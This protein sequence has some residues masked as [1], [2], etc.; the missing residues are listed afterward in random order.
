M[1]SCTRVTL[2]ARGARTEALPDDLGKAQEIF[3]RSGA[4][5]R[6]KDLLEHRGVLEDWYAYERKSQ[7]QEL[8]DWCEAEGMELED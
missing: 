1:R 2:R 4:Y 5:A 7:E 3:S 6:F 8:R